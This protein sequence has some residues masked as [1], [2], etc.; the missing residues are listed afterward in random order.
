MF[1]FRTYESENAPV[2]ATI[3]PMLVE[4]DVQLYSYKNFPRDRNHHLVESD[5]SYGVY[6]ELVSSSSKIEAVNK[7]TRNHESFM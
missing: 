2:D 7:N 5:G 6:G 1:G 3:Y 4:V